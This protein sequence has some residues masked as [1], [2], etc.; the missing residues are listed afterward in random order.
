MAR[1][2]IQQHWVYVSPRDRV[3]IVRFG[4][5]DGSA[6]SWPEIFETISDKLAGRTNRDSRTWVSRMVG[7][8]GIEPWTSPV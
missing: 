2:N 8:Q 5:V 4:L 6:E 1:G 7:A 3:V